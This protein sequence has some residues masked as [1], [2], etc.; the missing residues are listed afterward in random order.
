ML[1]MYNNVYIQKNVPYIIVYVTYMHHP[2]DQRSLAQSFVLYH[3]IVLPLA[4]LWF[5]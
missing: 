1:Y 5:A 3:P 4:M 2:S